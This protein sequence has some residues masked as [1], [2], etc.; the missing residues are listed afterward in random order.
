MK[1]RLG[2]V[3]NSSTGDYIYW[4]YNEDELF[5]H[6]LDFHELEDKHTPRGRAKLLLVGEQVEFPF[7]AKEIT[8]YED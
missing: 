7:I 8:Y 4:D 1:I 2:F 6:Q 5:A 3:A